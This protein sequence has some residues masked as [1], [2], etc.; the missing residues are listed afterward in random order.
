MI[1]SVN[2]LF[3]LIRHGPSLSPWGSGGP[4]GGG[5]VT[6]NN[7]PKNKKGILGCVCIIDDADKAGERAG[8]RADE[9]AAIRQKDRQDTFSL[10]IFQKHTFK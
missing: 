3:R 8:E 2:Q 7:T 10:Y 4:Q 6:P 5:R 9:V 1:N